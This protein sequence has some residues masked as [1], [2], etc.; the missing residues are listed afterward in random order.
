MTAGSLTRSVR[1]ASHIIELA[2]TYNSHHN[3]LAREA[4]SHTAVDWISWL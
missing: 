4:T 3:S 1:A 2:G